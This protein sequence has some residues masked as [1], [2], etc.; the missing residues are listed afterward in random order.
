MPW[1]IVLCSERNQ[2][3]VQINSNNNNYN[4]GDDNNKHTLITFKSQ[5]PK[6]NRNRHAMIS[7]IHPQ[8]ELEFVVWYLAA[9]HSFVGLWERFLPKI[10]AKTRRRNVAKWFPP[11]QMPFVAIAVVVPAAV[12]CLIILYAKCSIKQDV[13]STH[14][15]QTDRRPT[16]CGNFVLCSSKSNIGCYNFLKNNH[17]CQNGQ[18]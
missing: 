4:T 14:M 9:D 3:S 18:K 2:L 16:F 13:I 11:L 17:L 5:S 15:R 7:S 8:F 1:P 6:N 12:A 10:V